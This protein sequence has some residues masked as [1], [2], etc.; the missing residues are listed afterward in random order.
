[1]E[2]ELPRN[3]ADLA[4]EVEQ[5]QIEN[6]TGW[7]EDF[8]LSQSEV[9]EMQ[10]A[11]F[12]IESGAISSQVN[13]WVAKPGC[14][15][16]SILM[17]EAAQM[18]AQGYQVLYVNMDCGAA[19]LKYWRRLAND[20]GFK[21]ITPH[22]KGSGGIEDWMKGLA[23]M[24]R[25]EVDLSIVVIIVDTLKKIADLMSKAKAKAAMGLLRNLTAK[26]CTIICAAHANKHRTPD[27]KLVFEGV[28]DIENDCDN[29]IY[30]EG[31]ERDEHG[32]KTVTLEP[33]DKVRGIFQ[34]RSWQ[35]MED[36]SVISL[37]IVVDVAADLEVKTQLEKDETAIEV[38]RSGI[39]AG[40]HKRVELFNFATENKIGKREFDAVIKRYCRGQ[41]SGK[42]NPL[43][44]D[45][46]QSTNNA[47]YYILLDSALG[48]HVYIREDRTEREDR[49]HIS[50]KEVL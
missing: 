22:F 18:S 10:D 33:S 9:D 40:H 23:A 21:M 39:T 28:G 12:L 36:R 32:T 45:E 3:V 35:I 50:L 30:L 2:D 26:Q 44:R 4:G 48:E 8:V 49:T 15:K 41:S 6:P 7:M 27:G 1:M 25:M 19:D 31:S 43:W 13:I 46:R 42:T 5:E 37:D 17:H 24:S 47:S 16:T 34:K 38:I 29:L 11:K 14:G 20:G